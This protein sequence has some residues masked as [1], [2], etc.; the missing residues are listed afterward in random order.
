MAALLSS[1][2]FLVGT[3]VSGKALISKSEIEQVFLTRE[4]KIKMYYYTLLVLSGLIA[5]LIGDLYILWHIFIND[6]TVETVNWNF[7]IALTLVVFICCLVTLGTLAKLIQ[8]FFIK[9]HYKY[10]VQLINIGEVY[11]IGM[12]NE[13]ICICSAN[14]N[15][16]FVREDLESILI[17]LDD[18]IHKPL[19]REKIEIPQKTTWQKIIQLNH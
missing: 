4:K 2:A 5:F 16:E 13:E 10:K 19:T 3:F 6:K 14:P 1:I 9:E 8:T 15:A 17:K 18:L 11:I 12:M 7:A